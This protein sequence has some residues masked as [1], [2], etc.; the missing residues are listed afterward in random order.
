CRAIDLRLTVPRTRRIP[1]LW[2]S[3][4]DPSLQRCSP[5]ESK[6]RT[7]R[8]METVDCC[9]G[10]ERE[11]ALD[12]VDEAHALDPSPDLVQRLAAAVPPVAQEVVVLGVDAHE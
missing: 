4:E 12:R 6:A 1:T 11:L 3:G 9:L 8:H 2:V 7:S 5:R 10:G